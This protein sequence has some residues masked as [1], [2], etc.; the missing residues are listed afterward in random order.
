MIKSKAMTMF[1]MLGLFVMAQTA[2]AEK[3]T[4]VIHFNVPSVIQYTLT[5]PGE[6]AVTATGGGAATTD[7]EFNASSGTATCVEAKVVGGT[8]QSDGVPIFSFDNT[9]TV[10]LNLSV[11]VTASVPTCMDLIG[12]TTYACTTGT[13]IGT[14]AVSVIN[15]FTPAAAAQDWYMWTNF[16]ACANSDSTTRTLESYG[17]QS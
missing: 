7:I 4:T 1:F 8:T 11:N 5:L 3:T 12:K 15:D 2:F 10:N 6:S 16:T 17:I 13:V 14:T 9:G